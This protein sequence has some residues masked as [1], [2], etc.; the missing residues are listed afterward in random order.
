MF[1]NNLVISV[2]GDVERVLATPSQQSIPE[3]Q[4]VSQGTS[5]PS[6]VESYKSEPE[7]QSEARKPRS[8]A[9][10]SAELVLRAIG[11]SRHERIGLFVFRRTG[12]AVIHGRTYEY[13][14]RFSD[15]INT[16]W[17]IKG[18][19]HKGVHDCVFNARDLN[20]PVVCFQKRGPRD[21][22]EFGGIARVGYIN[23]QSNNVT[24]DFETPATRSS[25]RLVDRAIQ[26]TDPA[27][28]RLTDKE[29][30]ARLKSRIVY[31]FASRILEGTPVEC[32]L[33]CVFRN[34]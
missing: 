18:Q 14:N 26:K 11:I 32:F 34:G 2:D 28:L 23:V 5:F 30:F 24:L 9:D 31:T 21:A 13:D 1:E 33:L 19:A 20:M 25:K 16:Q 7:V 22:W 27:E 10:I 29:R 4:F 15:E 8:E 6:L 12:S 3:T 17:V